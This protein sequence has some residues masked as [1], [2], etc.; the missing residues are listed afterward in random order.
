[1]KTIGSLLAALSLAHTALACANL[2][3]SGTTLHGT[4]TKAV[5]RSS[6]IELRYFLTK[7]PRADGATMET[8]LRGLTNFNDRSDYSV[9]LMYLGRSREAVELL[10]NLEKERPGEYFVAANL[11]TAYELSGNNDEALRW[12][13]EG[14]RRNPASH[15]GTE[16]LH[17]KIL[18]AKIAQQKD[19][20]YFKK[21][22]V[23]E[24]RPDRIGAEVIVG[25]KKLPPEQLKEAIQ[26]Q[27]AERLQFVKPPDAPVASLLFDYAAI[28]AASRTLE[29]AK[30]LLKMAMEYGYPS[31][32]MQPLLKLYDQRIAW[33]KTKQYTRNTLI[34]IGVVSLLVLLL[35]SLYRR[36]IF[37]L[38]SKDLKLT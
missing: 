35:R 24:L 6:V 30:G 17:A 25:E 16:W 19:G 14:I 36:G 3:G 10:Q 13:N 12:I 15:K 22:S 9:A 32:N 21:H 8:A 1:M 23:L 33:R 37:V 38:S 29:S 2:T 28:E 11:G 20:D 26:H 34:G 4:E 18:E 27:L 31:E 7:D 5:R